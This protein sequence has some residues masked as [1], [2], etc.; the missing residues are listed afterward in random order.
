MNYDLIKLF[1]FGLSAIAFGMA[2]WA[3]WLTWIR[4]AQNKKI[5]DVY[6]A[7]KLT[8]AKKEDPRE[9]GY[10]KVDLEDEIENLN[11]MIEARNRE[12]KAKA[13]EL[14]AIARLTTPDD[15]D[16]HNYRFDEKTKTW[17]RAP[18]DVGQ[19]V[20]YI[21]HYNTI[22]SFVI[23]RVKVS[24][25][26]GEKAYVYYDQNGEDLFGDSVYSDY[27]QAEAALKERLHA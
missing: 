16:F 14:N 9:M 5:H 4:T 24:F 13:E 20:W 17:D 1:A 12:Y 18:Y 2:L 19:A 7:A 27:W 15:Y 25:Y 3:F 22:C 6:K 26:E 10:G 21:D 11:E 8:E 23:A